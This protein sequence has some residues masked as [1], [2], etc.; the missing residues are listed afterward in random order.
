[1]F[2]GIIRS[3]GEVTKLEQRGADATLDFSVGTLD[4]SAAQLGDSI[5]V[6]GVCL[7][8]TRLG[9]AHF[10]A[11]VSAETLACTTAA[12]WRAGR[13]VNLEPALRAGEA[14]GGHLVSGHVD[15]TGRLASIEADGRSLRLEIA[16]PDT[17]RR[18]VCQKGSICIDG[19][20]LTVNSL[21]G[22]CVSLCIIPHTL[23]MTTLG[24]L[25]V[26]DEVNIEVDQIARYVERLLGAN[27]SD[28]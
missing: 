18:Y 24:D 25:E 26:G 28:A 17:L 10:A 23:S 21:S 4:L 16:V 27:E 9:A 22:E 14:L 19:V 11:D 15:G 2:T 13:R 20:S 1:M 6:N 12:R 8:V 3:I 7:T 5:S